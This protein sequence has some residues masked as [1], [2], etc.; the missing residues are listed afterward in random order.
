MKNLRI[1]IDEYRDAQKYITRAE[2][3]YHEKIDSVISDILAD[4]E[5]KVITLAGPTCS[6]KTTTAEKLTKRIR[7]VGKNPVVLSI[8]D[9]FIDRSDRNNVSGESPDY[10]SVK[11]IDLESLE[12][13]AQGL[14]AGNTVKKPLFDFENTR[15]CGYQEYSPNENDIYI[16]EGIQAVY[17][18]VTSL[19]GDYRSIFIRVADDVERCLIKT[20][21]VFSGGSCGTTISATPRQSS[22]CI[23]G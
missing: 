20:R 18:E 6:G 16:F 8:D 9:F 2:H 7:E 12:K 4:G 19:L 11:A 5:T 1:N 15:R 22:H 13:F 10:D 17:P 3:D 14:L 21:Y 23:C